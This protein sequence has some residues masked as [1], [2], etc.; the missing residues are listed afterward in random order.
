[1]LA[2]NLKRTTFVF[3][4][5]QLTFLDLLSIRIKQRHGNNIKRTHLLQ[6]VI[7]A[8]KEYD[9]EGILL[10]DAS[11]QEELKNLVKKA[12]QENGK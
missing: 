12:L 9:R 1:M 11:N 7:D 10:S 5:D 3:T 2:Q 4:N 6:A 8:L